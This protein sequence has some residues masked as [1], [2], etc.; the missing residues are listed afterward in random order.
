MFLAPVVLVIED[1]QPIVDLVRDVLGEE[2]YE[3][4][5]VLSGHEALA[6]ALATSPDLILLDRH[7]G[8]M[9]G[10]AVLAQ[11]RSQPSLARVPVI[12]M[13]A[14]ATARVDGAVLRVSALLA[15]PFGL[16]DLLATV[17]RFVK[18]TGS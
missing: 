4:V 13:T 16:A 17:E 7:L 6:V 2:G 18:P 5:T 10:S 3:V 12:L 14:S 1:D 11:L 8:D 15:K 9:E